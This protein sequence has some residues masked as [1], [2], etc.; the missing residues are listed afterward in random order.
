[1]YR[2]PTL[3][4]T[5][6]RIALGCVVAAV[7]TACASVYR[8]HGYVPNARDLAAIEVGRD[9]RASV[10][11]A[12]GSPGATGVLDQSGLYYVSTRVRHFGALEPRPVS[13]EL[14][15]ITFNPSGTVRNIERFGL[16][17]GRVLE[18]ERRVT[19]NGTDDRAFLRQLLGN[20]G[21]IGPG[22]LL[23]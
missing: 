21:R 11:E 17:D 14:V 16:Q 6:R 12:V 8:D 10:L 13:R 5:A 19:D 23:E 4:K 20:L 9:T 18:L 3:K 1:M 7:C 15:A 2:F 22:A